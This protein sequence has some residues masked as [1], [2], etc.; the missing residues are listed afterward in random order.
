MVSYS[1]EKAKRCVL[2]TKCTGFQI[3]FL[4]RLEGDPL[5]KAYN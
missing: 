1:S 3:M 4:A 2:D 5:S